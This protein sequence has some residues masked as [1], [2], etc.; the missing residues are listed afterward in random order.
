MENEF[1][2]DH[3]R[4]LAWMVANQKLK[5]KIAIVVDS[6]GLPLQYNTALQK[7]IFHQKVGILEDS[8]GNKISFSGSDNETAFGWKNNIEE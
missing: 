5:I 6:K 1:V 3:V 4:A 7:G 8:K 2:R